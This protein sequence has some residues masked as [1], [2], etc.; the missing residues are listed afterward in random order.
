MTQTQEYF[1]PKTIIAA[2]VKSVVEADRY[3]WGYAPPDDLPVVAGQVSAALEAKY[4][5]VEMIVAT[6]EEIA[7]LIR[8]T[9]HLSP[10]CRVWNALPG[11]AFISRDSVT[12]TTRSFIDLDAIWL[13][14]RCNLQYYVNS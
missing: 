12:P 7:D 14:T 8:A 13:N 2:F 1:V 6:V 4:G 10:E 5:R 3:F 11:D 9:V